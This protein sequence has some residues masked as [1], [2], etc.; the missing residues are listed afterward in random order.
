MSEIIDIGI[1]KI[2]EEEE[3]KIESDRIKE[4]TSRTSI[5]TALIDSLTSNSSESEVLAII[6]KSV[7]LKDAI[8]ISKHKK[9]IQKKIGLGKK[10]IEEM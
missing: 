9:E 8:I 1:A 5:V 10:E 6:E 2:K 7:Q 4:Y 3:Q